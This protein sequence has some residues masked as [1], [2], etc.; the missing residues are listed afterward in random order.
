ML[1]FCIVENEHIRRSSKENGSSS[2]EAFEQDFIADFFHSRINFI[3]PLEGSKLVTEELFAILNRPMALHK[4]L[5]QT[6][7]KLLKEV[8]FFIND[9]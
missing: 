1:L 3:Q 9:G 7:T 6:V 5:R 4:N 8:T 2:K